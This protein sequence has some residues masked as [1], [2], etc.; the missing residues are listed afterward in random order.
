MTRRKKNLSHLELVGTF[1]KDPAARRGEF[2]LD[3]IGPYRTTSII[4]AEVWQ[5]VI[6]MAPPGVLTV[7]DAGAVELVV[8]ML[9]DLRTAK[10]PT[11][12]LCTALSTVL[13][14]L[15]MT[16]VGRAALNPPEI[17]KPDPEATPY[18]QF[19]LP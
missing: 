4:P 3:P 19:L 2:K 13:Y 7:A 10:R 12:A 1:D 5:E 11:P 14:R 17:P 16:P 6:A 15:G 18:A 9:I 8:R